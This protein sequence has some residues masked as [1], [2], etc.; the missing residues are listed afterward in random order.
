MV[1]RFFGAGAADIRAWW[2]VTWRSPMYATRPFPVLRVL[3]ILQVL[4]PH[5]NSPYAPEGS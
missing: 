5:E 3:P 1:T 4:L 2:R